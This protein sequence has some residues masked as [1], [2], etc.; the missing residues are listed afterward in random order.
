[1]PRNQENRGENDRVTLAERARRTVE[2]FQQ[3]QRDQ[4]V[5]AHNDQ[6]RVDMAQVVGSDEWV[7]AQ[8]RQQAAQMAA[9]QQMMAQVQAEAAAQAEQSEQA[10]ERLKIQ[11][12]MDLELSDEGKVARIFYNSVMAAIKVEFSFVN[13]TWEDLPPR[14]KILWLNAGAAAF[15]ELKRCPLKS[16]AATTGTRHI[17]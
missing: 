9:I 4:A 2:A 6:Y 5:T 1:M 10:Q 12:I 8:T 16:L 11:A 7:Q 14:E 15:E 17:E 13:P 3:R